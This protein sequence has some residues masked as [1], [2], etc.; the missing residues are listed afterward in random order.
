M[1]N[2][3]RLFLCFLFC[4]PASALAQQGAVPPAQAAAAAPAVAASRIALD[5]LVTD[6]ARKP[7]GE[8]E[9]SDFTLLDNDQPRKIL[10]FRRTD[11]VAGSKFDP[12]VEVIIVLD[13]FNVP[14][15]AVTLQR[16]ELDK[17]LRS[18]D[19][20]LAQPV[21]IFLLSSDGLRVQPA[22]SRDGNALAAALDHVGPVRAM[23]SASGVF[24]EVERLNT[25]IQAMQGIAENEA[26]KPGRKMV[27][28]IGLGWPWLEANAFVKSNE[29][30]RSY[31]RSIVQLSTKL[32]E[33][34]ITLYALYSRIAIS[35]IA[36]LAYM[37]PITEAKKAD[38]GNLGLQVLAAQSGGRVLDGSNDL[39]GQ[40][41]DCISDIGSYYT[42][43]FAAPPAAQADEYHS[44]KVGV[45]QPGLTARTNTGYYNQ[46]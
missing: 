1:S 30:R 38:S 8:L 27:I 33:A 10:S 11:G 12:P 46:P 36:Y 2:P 35:S 4:L 31:F 3:Q 20:H 37:K 14:Y 18:N 40:I 21:S 23:D 39:S 25:S 41:T 42:L 13:A 34:R 29:A 9:P 32:R 19:G 6:K 28:W 17:F 26:R 43:S 16:L 44:L 45:S 5:V 22:P 7:V 15:Q 24:G